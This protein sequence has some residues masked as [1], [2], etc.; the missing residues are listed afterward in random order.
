MTKRNVVSW[1]IVI[2]AYVQMK[3]PEEVVEVFRRMQVD[4]G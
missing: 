1:T 2:W 3:Q 4:E